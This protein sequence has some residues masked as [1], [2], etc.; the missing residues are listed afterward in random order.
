M[1]DENMHARPPLLPVENYMAMSSHADAHQHR[2]ISMSA[3][4]PKADIK[5][6]LVKRSANDPKETWVAVYRS[7]I[8]LLYLGH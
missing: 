4:P 1:T 8:Q 6:V 5:L 2:S 7:A 3:P